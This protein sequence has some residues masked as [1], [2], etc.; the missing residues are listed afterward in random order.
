MRIES[1]T[2]RE[3][4]MRLKWPFE[5]SFGVTQKRRVLLVE[6]IANGVT[7]WGE[8]TTGEAPYYNYETSDTAWLIISEF[9]APLLIGKELETA[10]DVPL[11]INRIRG[12][13]MAKAGV[14]NALW[15]IE[16]QQKNISLS[17]LLTGVHEE[18]PCGVSLGIRESPQSL[19][20]KVGEELSKGYQRVKMKIKPGK[21][22]D[23]VAAVR[24]QFP[25]AM[26]SV[27]ANSAYSLSDVDH[28]RK[29]DDYDLLMMEQPLQWDEIYSHAKLQK[30]IKTALC[31]DECI[32]HARH[33]EAAI[34][35]AA[36]R[37]LNIKVGRVGGHT[38]ARRVHDVCLQHSIPVWCGGMLE[39]GIGRAHN[40]AIS[41]LPNFALPGDVSASKRYWKE[42]IIDPEVE[43]T[44]RGTIRVPQGSGI[45]YSV[46]R[47][48]VEHL[49]VKKQ[50]WKTE[51]MVS[52]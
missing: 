6:M 4:E 39:S 32:S 50:T 26:L 37:I 10:S 7:G 33:A 12:H 16:A 14:E 17:K 43:I 18:I 48:F 11:L 42:D 49:T 21:D 22:L 38:E 29:F 27:D 20:E 36:C 13:Q 19:V 31:L 34:E 3:L 41:T 28:L 15:D 30:Q 45:G 1:I 47:E 46:K 2:L 52:A 51:V 23:F 35:L 9:I 24:K 44:P 8:V 40:I 5:T 25:R